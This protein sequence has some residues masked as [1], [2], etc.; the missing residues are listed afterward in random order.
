M[1]EKSEL[2]VWERKRSFVALL[3][4]VMEK[5]LSC[6]EHHK[7]MKFL[8]ITGLKLRLVKCV[9]KQTGEDNG[10]ATA[11]LYSIFYWTS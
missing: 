10:C 6:R 5:F 8:Q 4:C 7:L 3:L 2:T 11:T 9:N 1:S